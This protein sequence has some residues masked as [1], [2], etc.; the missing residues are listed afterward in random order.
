MADTIGVQPVTGQNPLSINAT[1]EKH[2]LVDMGDEK[3]DRKGP[4]EA[5]EDHGGYMVGPLS[6]HQIYLAALFRLTVDGRE[7]LRMLA[8]L[9]TSSSALQPLPLLPL[10][11]P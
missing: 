9:S 8:E 5:K 6:N 7:Y 3:T 4:G 10:E 11:L 1:S 2:T